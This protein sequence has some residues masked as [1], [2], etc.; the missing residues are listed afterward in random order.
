MEPKKP[1]DQLYDPHKRA[2]DAIDHARE[3]RESRSA[4][5]GENKPEPR[6]TADRNVLRCSICGYP[7]QSG[8]KPSVSVAFAKHLMKAHQSG[9]T[10]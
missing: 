10:S 1:F 5:R 6:L 3:M 7:F 4:D 2:Q 9:Q 8:E